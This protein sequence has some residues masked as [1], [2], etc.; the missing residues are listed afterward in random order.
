MIMNK[1][2]APGHKGTNADL[3]KQVKSNTEVARNQ[4]KSLKNEDFSDRVE[5]D[6][7]RPDNYKELRGKFWAFILYPDSAPDDWV[8]LLN[9]SGVKWAVSP[10]HA[11]DLNADYTPKKPHYHVI[12]IWPADTTY[13]NVK[14]L[15]ADTLHGTVPQ[16]LCSPVGYYRYFTHKDN[17]EK[18]PYS[19]RDITTGNGFDIADYRKVTREERLKMHYELTRYFQENCF[20]SYGDMCMKAFEFGFDEYELVTTNTIHFARLID[21]NR[22][23]K[24]KAKKG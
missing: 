19:E 8:E 18:A 17:P 13:N 2:K 24:A 15:T 5:V 22:Y 9:L 4:E 7:G 10:L 20:E 16:K 11:N 1:K 6:P 14:T 12:L 23:M 21:D 3:S